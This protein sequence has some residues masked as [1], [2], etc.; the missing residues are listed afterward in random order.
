MPIN[1]TLYIK[2]EDA[3][4]WD[5]A[6]NLIREPLSHF[7]SNHLRSVIAS[8]KAE[9]GGFGRIVLNFNENGSKAKSQ[10]FF[11]R[12]IL[13]PNA[14]WTP[15]PSQ[16]LEQYAVAITAKGNIVF[17]NFGTSKLPENDAFFTWGMLHVFESWDRAA[18]AQKNGNKILPGQLVAKAMQAVGVLTEE[19]DI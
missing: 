5:E 12:W 17:F 18:A 1:K 10:A 16:P 19:L 7:L 3:A 15:G 8:R 9:R 4:V 13:P 6:K 11:G 2:D 14:A